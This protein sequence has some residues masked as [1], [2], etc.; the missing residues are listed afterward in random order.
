MEWDV[1]SSTGNFSLTREQLL[2]LLMNKVVGATKPEFTAIVTSFN[3]FLQNRQTM[4]TCSIDQLITMG[5]SIGYYY[6]VFL[7]KND[8]EILGEKL[9]GN[10]VESDSCSP[11]D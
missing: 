3:D 10:M 9:D 11:S 1:K 7:E 4:S 6:R 8:V 5:F 2:D